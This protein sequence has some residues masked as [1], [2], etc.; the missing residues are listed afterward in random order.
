MTNTEAKPAA[1]GTEIVAAFMEIPFAERFTQ[2]W[3]TGMQKPSK[4]DIQGTSTYINGMM[5]SID[6]DFEQ[7]YLL[8]ICD[9]RG[10]NTWVTHLALEVH[11]TSVHHWSWL[12]HRPYR[13]FDRPEGTLITDLYQEFV[14]WYACNQENRRDKAND[15]TR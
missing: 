14:G 2:N 13:F 9:R 4:W 3:G 6:C 1:S 8:E 10:G 11:N 7:A 12:E 5:L 15:P